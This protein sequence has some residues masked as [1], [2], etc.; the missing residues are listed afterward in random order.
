MKHHGHVDKN[1]SDED[2][3]QEF[4]A[5]IQSGVPKLFAASL[6]PV[7]FP[8]NFATCMSLPYGLQCFDYFYASIRD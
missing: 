8:Y 4:E 5:M 6:G 7:G 2:I 3:M 1:A